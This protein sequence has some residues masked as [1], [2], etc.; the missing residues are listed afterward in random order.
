MLRNPSF[1]TQSELIDI[2]QSEI[3]ELR[4]RET[5]IQDAYKDARGV[6]GF[7][8]ISDFIADNFRDRLLMYTMNHPSKFILQHVSRKILTLLQLPV[9]INESI[10]PLFTSDRC[11]I[12]EC[13]K[14]MLN[15]STDEYESRIARLRIHGDP[16][17]VSE[18]YQSYSSYGSIN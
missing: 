14:R 3:A 7:V 4:K 18:Y 5:A 13:V 6:I 15:C 12:Y 1:K 11:M 17:V 9:H 8:P 10:D 16:A 2:A